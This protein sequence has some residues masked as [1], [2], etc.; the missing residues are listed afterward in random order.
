[1]IIMNMVFREPD[2]N[3][4]WTWAETDEE[5]AETIAIYERDGCVLEECWREEV[6]M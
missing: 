5:V 3:M 6:E 2:G 1:M 4:G